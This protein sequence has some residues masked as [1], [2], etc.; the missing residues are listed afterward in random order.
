MIRILS[1]RYV[2]IADQ[3]FSSIRPITIYL[4]SPSTF[5]AN[6]NRSGSAQSDWAA[7]KSIPCLSKFDLLLVSSNSNLILSSIYTFITH[8]QVQIMLKRAI[9]LTPC[10]G[11]VLERR[12]WAK[13]VPILDLVSCHNSNRTPEFLISLSPL[14]YLS[15]QPQ[16]VVWISVDRLTLDWNTTLHL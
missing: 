14:Q 12:S 8:F 15:F 6:C 7:K 13:S 16:L 3:C 9:L 11:S 2:M 4:R 1:S 10:Q 5:K